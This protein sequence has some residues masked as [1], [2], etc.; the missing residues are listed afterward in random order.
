MKSRQNWITIGTAM[1]SFALGVALAPSL[2]KSET[3][4]VSSTRE[5]K[6]SSRIT[7]GNLPDEAGEIP[8]PSRVAKRGEKK[9]ATE[10]RI[11][12]P[13]STVANILKSQRFN[14][15][16]MELSHGLERNLPYL[17]ASEVEIAEIKN[18]LKKVQDELQA[19]EKKHLKVLQSDD[20]R[21]QLDNSSM[22][23]VA[24]SVRQQFQND[25]RSTLPGD[26]AELLISSID[27]NQF[28]PTDKESYP[29]LK[30]TRS[31]S[32]RMNAMVMT[33]FGGSGGQ[34][35]GFADD[36]TPIPADQ[37]FDERWKPLIKGLTLLP[38]N[39]N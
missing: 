10:P 30:I 9:K 31:S 39:E 15:N 20:T 34:V 25:L 18:S 8:T 36:G 38:Q 19:E 14:S 22:Q 35:H 23:A 12:I 29:T 5:G 7:S 32:G 11:S 33:G 3:G 24:E 37:V 21:I 13:M 28:Y 4:S 1:A 16:F 17:G 27:W 26:A 2:R 6:P